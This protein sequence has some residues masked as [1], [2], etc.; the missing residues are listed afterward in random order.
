MTRKKQSLLIVASAL[1]GVSTSAWAAEVVYVK[2]R[3]GTVRSAKDATVAPVTDV[4]QGDKLDVIAREGSWLKVS[5]GGKEGYIQQNAISAEPVGGKGGT[6]GMS[7][8]G[9]TARGADAGLAGRGL[10][11]D[12][13]K[14]S[15]GKNLNVSGLEKMLVQNEV[16]RHKSGDV[17]GEFVRAGNVGPAKK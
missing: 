8:S 14:W 11:D 3:S 7:S 5:V 2:L 17:L 1:I 9:Q 12:A 16:I 4:K 13:A 6:L 15:Q 10:G